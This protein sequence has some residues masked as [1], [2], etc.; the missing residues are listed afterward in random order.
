M[1]DLVGRAFGNYSLNY[2]NQSN[3]DYNWTADNLDSARLNFAFW[4][5]CLFGMKS[6][7]SL[8][9]AS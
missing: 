3:Q 8:S 4:N 9:V 1:V 7:V 6:F 5:L 2:H